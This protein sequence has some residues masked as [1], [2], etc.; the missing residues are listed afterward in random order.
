MAIRNMRTEGDDILR[1][2]SR[3]VENFDRRLWDLLDDMGDTLTQQNG[4]GLA[5]VQVGI[6][7]RA[8]IVSLEEGEQPVEFINPQLLEQN[9][10]QEVIEGC[11][12]YP[13]QWGMITRPDRV[14]LRAQDRQGEW[15]EMEGEGLMAQAMLHEYGHLDGHAFKDDPTF[16]P[17]T[18]EEVEAMTSGEG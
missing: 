6:L 17:L 16:T 4:V 1:K 3:V 14:K 13:G 11:L 18:E 15:F 8:F 7:R 5:A 2:K 12:S 9:G 10:S